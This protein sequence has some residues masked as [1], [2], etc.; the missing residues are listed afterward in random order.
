M[1]HML[2]QMKASE[3][4]VVSSEAKS[5]QDNE[6]NMW[7]NMNLNIRLNVKPTEDVDVTM[8]NELPHS[9]V[10][11]QVPMNKQDHDFFFKLSN[12]SS[13][14]Q[15]TNKV[16]WKPEKVYPPL[17]STV[18]G[19]EG[20]V[21]N[22]DDLYSWSKL[23]P[24]KD[25]YNEVDFE[26]E[27][28]EPDIRKYS[29]MDVYAEEEEEEV[30]AVGSHIPLYAVKTH[31][32]VAMIPLPPYHSTTSSP[33]TK[34]MKARKQNV[35]KLQHPQHKSLHSRQK[36]RHKKSSTVQQSVQKHG[37]KYV[38]PVIPDPNSNS[39]DRRLLTIPMELTN[40]RAD[41]GSPFFSQS[42]TNTVHVVVPST[43]A[44]VDT[45]G[46]NK[47]LSPAEI[48]TLPQ[49]EDMYRNGERH[50]GMTP[51]DGNNLLTY[52]A[53][54]STPA[55]ASV[56]RLP[57]YLWSDFFADSASGRFSLSQS[58]ST[59]AGTLPGLGK[60]GREWQDLGTPSV[61][62]NQSANQEVLNSI[63]G[64]DAPSTSKRSPRR[65]DDLSQG[66]SIF[67]SR[68]RKRRDNSWIKSSDKSELEGTCTPDLSSRH[69][70]LD[71]YAKKVSRVP[72][73]SIT[74]QSD[75][76]DKTTEHESTNRDD[77][78]D[79]E[80]TPSLATQLEL[81]RQRDF[82]RIMSS[83]SFATTAS[84]VAPLFSLNATPSPRKRDTRAHDKLA[85]DSDSDSG[86]SF[87][88]DN[89]ISPSIA[90]EVD[91]T[92]DLFRM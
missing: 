54:S 56:N 42:N 20:A 45:M 29:E 32:G 90:K 38:K 51:V 65:G 18:T 24:Q 78:S 22:I 11:L 86:G 57:D 4:S 12:D 17:V 49:I 3:A 43:P 31:K 63:F 91:N 30:D 79:D 62:T 82:S 8:S 75:K 47:I 40:L 59:A 23:I 53:K 27:E 85:D 33:Q 6:E 84:D 50:V 44:I 87:I 39:L 9:I 61:T 1:Q 28:R 71:F 34:H 52:K 41:N 67:K 55:G 58:V 80:P 25:K 92:E 15:M 88:S 66:G 81:E 7:R 48:S 26:E 83:H 89:S 16:L 69:K 10:A 46:Y 5:T 19:V 2:D 35:G 21:T 13:L 36:P 68:N 74:L 37:I 64:D 76:P 77:S 70:N 14:M 72:R 73:N 60:A